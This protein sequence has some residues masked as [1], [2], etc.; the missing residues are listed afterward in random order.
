[1]PRD[2]DISLEEI[3]AMPQGTEK[4][5]QLIVCGLAEDGGHHTTWFMEQALLALGVDPEEPRKSLIEAGYIDWE[6]GIIP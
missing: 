5:I 3:D 6:P 1:M 2:Y 4:A